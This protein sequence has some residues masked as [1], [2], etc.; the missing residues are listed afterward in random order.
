MANKTLDIELKDLQRNYDNE[1]DLIDLFKTVWDGKW[2]IVLFI[3]VVIF[4]MFGYNS[5]K[6]INFVATTE[7]RP[8]AT[9]EEDKYRLYNQL[10]TNT[11]EDNEND[12]NNNKYKDIVIEYL[13]SN[14][15]E[16][17]VNFLKESDN[18]KITVFAITNMSLL[19]QYIEEIIEGTLLEVGI[20]KFNLIEREKFDNEKTYIEA[21]KKFASEI[22]IIQPQNT[23]G[24]EG[25]DIIPY[26][27]IRGEY[28]DTKKWKELLV[29]IDFEVNQKVKDIVSN[30]FETII[31]VERQK[32]DFEL[33]DLNTE[34]TNTKQE[35]EEKVKNKLAF[36][37]EQAS[38]A[39]K[40]NIPKNTIENQNF[41]TSNAEVT[42]LQINNT[43][44]L[45]GYIALEEEIRLINNR[46]NKTFFGQQIY[47]L[48]K[49]KRDLM[50]NK[51]LQRAVLLFDN[52]PIKRGAFKATS[53]NIAATK[54]NYKDK[55]ISH[56]IIA[57]IIA[58]MIG[59]VYVLITNSF[60]NRKKTLVT[61]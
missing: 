30:R 8:I 21:V 5:K 54:Y 15:D 9:S 10:S 46:K 11:D 12:D 17:I 60:A 33:E 56:Y 6:V 40:L 14:E 2:K 26:H 43:L 18:D 59:A 53:V 1:I 24:K 38:I 31:S 32:R 37:A 4:I 3:I 57:I 50:Q 39:R 49:R 25:R 58:G 41:I 23:D 55:S 13:I 52:T 44:Y 61:S 35:Y 29:F 27:T 20:K 42:N 34:I 47:K 28:S 16:D 45:R 7:I 19:N 48:E 36:L 51:R 22:L